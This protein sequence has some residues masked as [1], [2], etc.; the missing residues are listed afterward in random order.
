M[1]KVKTYLRLPE[2]KILEFDREEKHKENIEDVLK[3]VD[4]A[5]NKLYQAENIVGT[6]ALQI[7]MSI[8]FIKLIQPFLSS[9]KE[10]GKI[11]LLNP[12]YYDEESEVFEKTCTY[13]K[14]LENIL[15]ESDQEVR[16]LSV[17]SDIIRKMG[18]ILK[19]HPLTKNIYTEDNFIKVR[20]ASTF[21]IV[22]EEINNIDLSLFTN[23]EDIIGEIYEHILNKYVKNNSRELGQFF[24]PRKLMRLILDYKKDRMSNLFKGKENIS[25]YDSCMGT[26]GWLVTAYNLLKS[27][28]TNLNLSGGEV[29]PETFQYGVMNIINTLKEFPNDIEC[30]SSLT[31]INKTKHT[32]ICTNPPF[33]SKNK[34][35]FDQITKNLNNDD[36][37]KKNKINVD[38]LYILKKDDPPIQFLELDVFKLETDGMCII[39][40]PY[41]EFFSGKSFKATREHFINEVNI[42]DIILVPGGTF[43]HTG[44][45]TCVLIFEKTKGGTKEITFSQIKNNECNEIEK[46]T[47]VC[48]KDILEEEFYSWYHMDYLIDEMVNNLSINMSNYEWIN[49]GTMFS[50][51]KGKLQSTEVEEDLNGEGVFINTTKKNVFKKINVDKCCLDNENVFITTFLPK[52]KTEDESYLVLQYYNGKCNY[53]NLLSKIVIKDDYVDK[54]NCK[55]IYYYLISIKNYLEKTYQKGTCQRSLDIKNFNR[56]KIPIPNLEIQNKIIIDLDISNSKIHHLEKIVE[57]MQKDIKTQFDWS[58]QIDKKNSKTQYIEFG[59]LFTLEKGKLQSSKIEEDIEGDVFFITKEKIVDVRKIKSDI[60]FENGLF[61]ASA[62]NG[63]GKCPI[64]FIDDKCIHSNLMLKLNLINPKFKINLK[65][66]YYLLMSMNQHIETFYGKGSCNVSLDIK[67]FNRMKIQ[68]PPIE[69]QNKYID[70][71]NKMEEIINRWEKDINDLKKIEKNKFS[72]LFEINHE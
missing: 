63:N 51:E 7:I 38:T 8:L 57:V 48:K 29:E 15:I 3:I 58:L 2:F 39:V 65:Y 21:K 27:K 12:I 62:F 52:G 46:I 23:N 13:F 43:T 18:E 50:L 17:G 33:N 22:I 6:K 54:I 14:N 53:S 5:H 69:N 31:H 71:L 60:Y 34:I 42:T 55:Y 72:K 70:D 41:G 49:F 44:I 40:L 30:N 26:S 68:I 20:E 66:L 32:L 19:L 16:N 28:F 24:T 9:C 59:N 1:E 11:D 45:K 4:S 47:S 56:M 61:I 35:K 37:T 25:I 36:Y 67:N 10:K 64:R